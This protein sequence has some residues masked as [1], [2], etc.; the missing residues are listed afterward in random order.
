MAQQREIELTKLTPNEGQVPGL[1][2]NPRE[3]TRDALDKLVRS[4]QEC[5]EMLEYRE[6][7][8]Y[9]YNGSLVIIGGN[10]R[11]RALMELGIKTAYIKELPADMPV[12]KLRE[13]TLKDNI[14][15]GKWD[16][17]ELA[18]QWDDAPLADWGMPVWEQEQ[19]E[20]QQAAADNAGSDAAPAPAGK[21]LSSEDTSVMQLVVNVKDEHEQEELYNELTERGYECQVLT[22]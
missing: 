7:L 12:D 13:I 8:V 14:A 6:L 5:P 2:S 22:L 1:P 21:D 19:Q 15:Y 11:Y 10:M 17:D 9:P 4:I 3:I 20:E 16:W 18:N